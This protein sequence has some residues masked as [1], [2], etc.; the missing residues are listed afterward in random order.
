MKKSA[1]KD[2]KKASG[3]RG[4]AKTPQ[5]PKTSNASKMPHAFG[6]SNSSEKPGMPGPSRASKTSKTTKAFEVPQA[7]EAASRAGQSQLLLI[8]HAR[9]WRRGEAKPQEVE[10]LI[11]G[12][13]ILKLGKDLGLARDFCPIWDAGGDLLIPAYVDQHVHITG[14]GGEGGFANQVP[15]IQLSTIVQGGVATLGGLLGTDGCTRSVENVLAKCK[16]LNEEGLSCFAYTGSYVLPPATICGSITRDI[17]LIQEIIG[18]KVAVSDHRSCGITDDELIKVG[19]AARQG[20]VLAN[21]AGVVHIHVGSGKDGIGLIFRALEKSDLPI[22]VFRPT[23]METHFE[24]S[25]SFASLGGYVDLT[26]GGRPEK[27]AEALAR[28]VREAPADRFTLSSDAN[29]SMP[30]WNERKEIIGI[31]ASEIAANQACVKALVEDQKIP[32]PEAAAHLSEYPA[33]ALGLFPKK[34]IIAEGSDA[35]LLFLDEQLN[36]RSLFA[37]GE[38]FL[39]KGKLLRRGRFEGE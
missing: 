19:F 20:G 12:G 1:E 36:I 17:V 8:K 3:L 22:S 23:H 6:A 38:C 18:V 16:G 4:A 2:M 7:S 24:E 39:E 35:D 11:G 32:L 34:G 28:L 27:T 37:R 5:K 29:G 13:K 10:L 25:L 21:K 15:P 14:G 26:T 30:R 31:R 33:R 9:L